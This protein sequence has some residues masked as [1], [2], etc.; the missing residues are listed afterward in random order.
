MKSLIIR[1]REG[2]KT[3]ALTMTHAMTVNSNVVHNEVNIMV[4]IVVNT[5]NNAMNNSKGQDVVIAKLVTEV[6]VVAIKAV[7]NLPDTNKT[8]IRLLLKSTKTKN[9]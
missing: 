7:Q 6:I 2:A 3:V 1:V 4:V 8:D 9:N 5:V